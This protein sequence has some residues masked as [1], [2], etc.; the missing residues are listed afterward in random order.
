MVRFIRPIAAL[1]LARLAVQLVARTP[2]YRI[3]PRCCG[4]AINAGTRSVPN[5]P[6]IRR[7]P[8]ILIAIHQS[9]SYEF[10]FHPVIIYGLAKNPGWPVHVVH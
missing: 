6:R 8:Y 1:L 9:A 3:R 4:E 2:Y 5:C 10:A 7:P